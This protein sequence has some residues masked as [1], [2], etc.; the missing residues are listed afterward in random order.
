[1]FI[2]IDLPE[3]LSR[4]LAEVPGRKGVKAVRAGQ[5]HLTLR[6]LGDTDTG[7]MDKIRKALNSVSF[8][9]FSLSLSGSG[10][11]PRRGNPGIFWVGLSE[12]RKLFGLKE[13]IDAAL[14]QIGI[15]PEK[16]SFSPHITVARIKRKPAEREMV[17]L[18]EFAER[19]AGRTFDVPGFALYSS[20]LSDKGA[21]HKRELFVSGG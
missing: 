11:F 4:A 14:E 6:F 7:Y 2:A 17:L 13:K 16:R 9:G 12:C 5:I 18:A 20:V 15:D 3:G 8:S 21:E 1:M 19:F 10:F